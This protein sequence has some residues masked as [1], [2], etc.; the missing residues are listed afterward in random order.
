MNNRRK[1]GRY[2]LKSGH[3]RKKALEILGIQE[4]KVV[5]KELNDDETTLFMVDSNIYR[6][7]VLSSEKAFAY[8]MKLE[9]I[10]H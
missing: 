7:R 1:K 10:K 2:E 5:L 6:K 4:I 9:A 3:R 8:N